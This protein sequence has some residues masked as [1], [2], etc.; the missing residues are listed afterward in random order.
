MMQEH[1][2]FLIR[3]LLGDVLADRVQGIFIGW[4]KNNCGFV[5]LSLPLNFLN[6]ILSEC[7]H[8]IHYFKAYFSHNVFLLMVYYL[9]LILYSFF[10]FELI[11]EKRQIRAIFCFF[12]LNRKAAEIAR[13]INDAF[14][15]SYC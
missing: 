10:T 3:D 1:K 15:S 11:M 7:A 8:V 6:K 14:D 4:C 12:K 13:N 5:V 2:S 9:L